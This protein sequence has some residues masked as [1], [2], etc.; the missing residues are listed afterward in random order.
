M[1]M[2]TKKHFIELKQYGVGN[3]GIKMVDIAAI[4]AF[5]PRNVGDSE[6]S[7]YT[8][9]GHEFTSYE[10]SRSFERRL[11]EALGSLLVIN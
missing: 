7:V 10:S 9:G 3:K 11:R 2:S 8:E 6:T 5:T 1:T 4:I